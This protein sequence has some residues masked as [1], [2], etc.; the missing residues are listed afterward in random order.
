MCSIQY[1]Y[2]DSAVS[3]PIGPKFLRITDIQDG[4]VNWATVPYCTCGP[5]QARRFQLQSGDIVFARTGA[6]TGKSFLISSCPD[7]VFA[8][9]LIRLRPDQSAVLARYLAFYLQ[10]PSYWAQ[11][12][13]ARKGSAQPGVNAAIL[14]TLRVPLAPLLEQE[15]ITAE[16]EKQFSRLDA[17]VATLKRVQASLKRYRAA[18]LQAA[19]EGRLVHTEAELASAERRDYESA[20]VSLSR[21]KTAREKQVSLD[22]VG[23]HT[24]PSGWCWTT[25]GAIGDVRLGRQ[26]SPKNRSDEYPTPYVRAANITEQGL[27]LDDVLEMDFKP[28]ERET[29]RLTPGDVVLSEASGSVGQVGKPAIWRG[30]IAGCCFQNTVIRFRPFLI[31]SAFAHLVFRHFYVS[32]VFARVAAGVGINHLGAERFSSIP[33][34]LPPVAEQARI[35]AEVDRRLSVVDQV[36]EVIADNLKR[37]ERLRQAILKRAFEGKLVPQDPNEEPASVLLE[38]ILSDHSADGGARGRRKGRATAQLALEAL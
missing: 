37:A 7:A 32:Q 11:I 31:T 17:A 22:G 1:G 38:R 30:E 36:E 8:S 26:R 33:F 35:V 24:L 25:L 10:S 23:L 18:V 14:S 5:D 6:T 15:R 34:P 20:E 28:H 12:M 21:R 16:I 4:Q 27:R 29:Y 13:S 3:Q 19:C 2:T 9:Y